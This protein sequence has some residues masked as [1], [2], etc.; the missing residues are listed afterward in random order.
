MIK[1]LREKLCSFLVADNYLVDNFD[2][3]YENWGIQ[4]DNVSGQ[5]Q[6]LPNYDNGLGLGF[7][8]F[9]EELAQADPPSYVL[10]QASAFQK[11]KGRSL[12]MVELLA[13]VITLKLEASQAWSERIRAIE[14]EF[15]I[16]LFQRIPAGWVSESA[17]GFAIELIDF[18]RQQIGLICESMAAIQLSQPDLLDSQIVD[19]I[20]ELEIISGFESCYFE[21]DW[22]LVRVLESLAKIEDLQYKLALTGDTAL[23]K[24]A[25]EID[26]FC[27]NISF[28]VQE[29]PTGTQLSRSREFR[30]KIADSIA[31]LSPN[32]VL[33]ERDKFIELDEPERA[34]AKIEYRAQFPLALG[35]SNTI[36]LELDFCPPALELEPYQ[37]SS[38]L[39]QYVS[40][41]PEI[42]RISCTST[43]ETAADKLMF[44]TLQIM[45][46]EPDRP[47][48]DPRTIRHFYDLTTLA[49]KLIDNPEW[50]ALSYQ[51]I[52][53]N[54]SDENNPRQL[55]TGLM[56]KLSGNRLYAE[57]YADFVQSVAYGAS[58]SFVD[59][60]DSLNSLSAKVIEQEADRGIAIVQ[61]NYPNLDLDVD[62]ELGA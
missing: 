46:Q 37:L 15:I 24:G 11:S 62:L 29:S 50:A 16:E 33:I 3:H 20:Q 38:R 60:L 41:S 56:E 32:L 34:V 54:L 23:I 47:E 1:L 57:H 6:L 31:Q 25:G 45:S 39:N 59:A 21:K 28:K 35:F 22:Y 42:I 27:E 26:R 10:N 51:T 13:E 52:D 49:P 53:R 43:L 44:L 36:Q 2:R 17:Q 14:P 30:I 8:M 12:P 48:Y 19:K 4:I 61:S 7:L 55:L 18:N 40:A 58:K 5:E 9:E